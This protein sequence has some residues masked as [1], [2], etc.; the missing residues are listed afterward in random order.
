MV[1]QLSSER[2]HIVSGKM[3]VETCCKHKSAS[4]VHHVG[5]CMGWQAIDLM[6][7]YWNAGNM[8]WEFHNSLARPFTFVRFSVSVNSI[9]YYIVVSDDHL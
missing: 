9:A 3:Q 7:Q 2:H 8:V 1:M 5:Q 4:A 6:P